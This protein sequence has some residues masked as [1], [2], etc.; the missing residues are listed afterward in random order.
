MNEKLG[1]NNQMILTVFFETFCLHATKIQIDKKKNYAL[2]LL[3]NQKLT[4]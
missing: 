2:N 1:S 4:P 3:K